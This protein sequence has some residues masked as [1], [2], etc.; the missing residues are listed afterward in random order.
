MPT[1]GSVVHAGRSGPKTVVSVSI[2]STPVVSYGCRLRFNATDPATI[3]SAA[4][5]AVVISSS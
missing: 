3:I 5:V 4:V 1:Y 2:A